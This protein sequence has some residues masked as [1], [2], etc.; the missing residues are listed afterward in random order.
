MRMFTHYLIK[1]NG[2]LSVLKMFSL[3]WL[4]T[5]LCLVAN[6]ARHNL[7]SRY[8]HLCWISTSVPTLTRRART[9]LCLLL[10]LHCPQFRTR[11]GKFWSRQLPGLLLGT[12]ILNYNLENFESIQSFTVPPI[13][14]SCKKIKHSGHKILSTFPQY[15]FFRYVEIIHS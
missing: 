3:C 4:L 14:E 7:Q 5:L 10:S 15:C 11:S 6:L 12:N 13:W 8:L 1:H 2:Y 9:C